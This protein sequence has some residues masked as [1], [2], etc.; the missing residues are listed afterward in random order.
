[1]EI[2]QRYRR[3]Y[4]VRRDNISE[5]VRECVEKVLRERQKGCVREIERE[6]REGEREEK[7]QIEAERGRKEWKRERVKI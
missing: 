5:A 2:I 1:M 3:L 6:R 4:H 7:R